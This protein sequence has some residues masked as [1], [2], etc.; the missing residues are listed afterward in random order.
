MRAKKQVT[1]LFISTA[2]AS[3]ILLNVFIPHL[4]LAIYIRDYTPGLLTA[5]LFNLPVSIA[6][7]YENKRFYSNCRQIFLHK[8]GGLL[9]GYAFFA[10]TLRIVTLV[11]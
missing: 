1:Y 3:A 6:V 4:L 11:V 8:A 2:L 9:L 5:V 7:L 10:I